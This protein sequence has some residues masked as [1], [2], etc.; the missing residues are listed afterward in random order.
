MSKI[1]AI[2]NTDL[3]L[4]IFYPIKPVLMEKYKAINTIPLLTQIEKNAA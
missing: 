2:R 3:A 1:Q 4:Q